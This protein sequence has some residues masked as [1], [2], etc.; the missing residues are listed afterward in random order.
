MLVQPTEDEGKGSERPSEPQPIPF[1]PHPSTDQHETQTNL[2]PRPSPTSYITDSIP[3]G[4]GG[5]HDDQAKEIKHLKAQIKKLKKKA[6]PVITHH[7]AWMKSVSMKQRLAGK[8]SLKK[9]WMQIESISKEGRKSA[10]AEPT[11]H[12]DPAFNELDD[13]VI[14]YMETEDA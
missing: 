7:R 2:S 12:K 13:D 14:D 1:P 6:K 11:V 9:Q 5:N 10:K 3:E 4:S 8:K